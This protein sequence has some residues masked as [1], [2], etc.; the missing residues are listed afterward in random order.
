VGRT[1]VAV[2]S[3][4]GSVC[5]QCGDTLPHADDFKSLLKVFKATGWH[6]TRAGT[7]WCWACIEKAD[8]AGQ[9]VTPKRERPAKA[10]GSGSWQSGWAEKAGTDKEASLEAK[11]WALEEKQK[12]MVVTQQEMQGNI[13]FLLSRAAELEAKPYPQGQGQASTGQWSNWRPSQ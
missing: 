4:K 3:S 10:A 5:S 2:T 9:E 8:K 6:R 1:E 7:I 12:A 13:G 11:V